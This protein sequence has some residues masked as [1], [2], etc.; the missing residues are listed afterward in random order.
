M[1]LGIAAGK[2]DRHG[3][4]GF[5]RL[6]WNPTP[7]QGIA[8]LELVMCM[9]ILLLLMVGI[10]WLGFSVVGQ[11]EVTVEARHKAWQQR[12]ETGSS[13]ALNF[14]DDDY[15]NEE[16]STEVRVSPLLDDV[17][18][19]ESSHDVAQGTWDHRKLDL[20]QAPSWELYLTAALNAKTGGAQVAYEDARSMLRNLQ[21]NAAKQV[22]EEMMNVI[23]EALENP[24][25]NLKLGANDAQR[26]NEDKADRQKRQIEKEIETA[27]AEINKAEKHVSDLKKEKSK[28]TDDADRKS[29]TARIKIGGNKVKRLKSRLARLKSA[30]RAMD[31]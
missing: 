20:N 13:K 9:P 4:S 16:A 2:L 22:A 12:F 18:G 3:A 7:Q 17:S 24:L 23:R 30:R 1:L 28:S 29:L 26:D 10:V 19:P 5:V 27:K 11:S 8:T 21:Q 14:L 31:D 15:V 6:A 25:G